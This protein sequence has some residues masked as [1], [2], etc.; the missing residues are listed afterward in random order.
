MS[1]PT[2]RAAARP[3][4]ADQQRWGIVACAILLGFLL[5]GY[6]ALREADNPAWQDTVGFLS[7]GLYI[8]EHGGAW[9]ALREA[10]AGVFPIVE[11]H[12]LY[13]M[14]LAPFAERSPQFFLSAK[15][16]N[17]ALG[18][19]V[20]ASL[21]WMARRRYGPWAA[22]LAGAMYAVS[23]SLVIASSHVNCEPLLVLCILWM[24]WWMVSG[25]S[26]RRWALAGACGGLAFLTKGSGLLVLGAVGCALLLQWRWRVVALK[27]VWAF[28]LAA[29]ATM[30][31]VLVRNVIRYGTPLYEGVN[32]H[33]MWFENWDDI[34]DPASIIRED[35]YGVWT[36]ERDALPT[37]ATYARRHGAGAI[38]KRFVHGITPGLGIAAAAVTPIFLTS[39]RAESAWGL[40]VL[41]L[42]MAG[43]WL[44]DR[45]ELAGRLTGMLLGATTLFFT[46]YIFVVKDI[47]FFAPVVPFLLAY[48]AC[49]L[50]RLG[51]RLLGAARAGW[52]A[53]ALSGLLVGAG[54]ARVAAAGSLT[55]SRPVVAISPA[56]QRLI[57]WVER[58]V[59]EGDTLLTGPTHDFFG[60]TWSLHAPI[61]LVPAPH[62][63][64]REAFLEYL[65]ERHVTYIVMHPGNIRG[66]KGELAEALG[67]YWRAGD[68]GSL[69]E[70]APLPGWRRVYTDP[71][72][73]VQFMVYRAV[74]ASG[75]AGAS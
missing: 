43:W 5:I 44:A 75:A 74:Q 35:Q 17:L 56:Y 30:S 20:L 4:A 50:W 71:G 28:A 60:M 6:A 49:S 29:L 38:A 26:V 69:Q 59:V 53:A 46:W 40:G 19:L 36:V 52:V 67:P 22:L 37:A 8:A 70:L 57:G 15:G 23:S 13:P 41:A 63:S 32:A 16:V 1:D 54:I 27:P 3:E 61:H 33:S 64:T 31:P 39:K 10:Y 24:W 73:P 68:D 48:A 2:P 12:L 11:R 66:R 7:H 18:V 14:L 25:M 62:V 45:R 72:Q 9:G 34:G 42:A 47:R 51:S 58:E 21:M 65:A 55:A